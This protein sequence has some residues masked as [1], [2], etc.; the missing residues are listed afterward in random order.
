M[1][2]IDSIKHKKAKRSH[3]PSREEAGFE[4]ANPKV[5]SKANAQY[6]VNPVVHRGQDPEFFFLNK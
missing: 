2:E 6:P 5:Q 4:D 1:A 3:I